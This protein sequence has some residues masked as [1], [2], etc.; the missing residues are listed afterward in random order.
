MPETTAKPVKDLII[1]VANYRTVTQ[2]N[3]HQA[4]Q[5]MIA[6]KPDR[7]WALPESLIDDG[8]LPTENMM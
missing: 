4:I 5:A 6:T 1:D 8:Y 7:F 2:R 3:E